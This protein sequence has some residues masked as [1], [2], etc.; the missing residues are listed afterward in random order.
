MLGFVAETQ[1]TIYSTTG[2]RNRVSWPQPNL[3]L[4]LNKVVKVIDAVVGNAHP[5]NL[6]FQPTTNTSASLSAGNQQLTTN[7]SSRHF[8]DRETLLC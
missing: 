4:L 8:T 7:N 6:P 3:Q 2:F 5:T 1:P